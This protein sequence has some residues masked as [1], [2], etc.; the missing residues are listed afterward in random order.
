MPAS[1]LFSAWGM[2]TAWLANGELFVQGTTGQITAF[3]TRAL[4]KAEA[5]LYTPGYFSEVPRVVGG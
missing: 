1:M 4:K 5:F 3:P 2:L